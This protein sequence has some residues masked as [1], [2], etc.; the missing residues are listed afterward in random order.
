[1]N[2]SEPK[3]QPPMTKPEIMVRSERCAARL[4]ARYPDAF[5]GS[6]DRTR[7]MSMVAEIAYM[8]G[9]RDGFSAGADLERVRST[10]QGKTT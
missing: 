5:E 2:L 10:N 3:P 7:I 4:R 1:M 6:E 8:E 9:H